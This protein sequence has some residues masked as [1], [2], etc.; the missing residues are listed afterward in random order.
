[1]NSE[2]SKLTQKQQATCLRLDYDRLYRDFPTVEDARAAL[3]VVAAN[4]NSTRQD[5]RGAIRALRNSIII[6]EVAK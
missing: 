1:M 3:D 4:A 2:F 5:I 6:R